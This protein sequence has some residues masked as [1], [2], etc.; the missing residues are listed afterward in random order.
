MVAAITVSI[1]AN[2]RMAWVTRSGRKRAK[3]TGSFTKYLQLGQAA[4]QGGPPRSKLSQLRLSLG[5]ALTD[6]GSRDFW[7]APQK[8]HVAASSLERLEVSLVPFD[9]LLQPGSLA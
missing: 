5:Q 8:K 4:L 1:L 6:R 2:Q 9:V 3:P 7:V